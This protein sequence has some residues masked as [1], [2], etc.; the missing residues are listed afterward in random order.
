MRMDSS[1]DNPDLKVELRKRLVA[2]RERLHE[3]QR[4]RLDR[5]ICVHLLRFL[6]ERDCLNLAAF[7]AFRGEPDLM[8]ALEALHH[9]GRRVHLPVVTGDEMHFR[10]WT[11]ASHMQS[12][13][14]GIPEPV[15]GNEIPAERLELVMMPL[16]AFSA[17]GTRLGMGA[18]YYDR[19]FGFALDHPDAGPMLVGAAYSLQEVNSLPAQSWDVPLDAVITD[20]GLRVFRD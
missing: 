1:S 19:A 11:P 9:A 18:G 8:P 5:Q 20:R 7:H 17:T 16:V 4:R 14:F 15:D 10:R 3:H 12:N 2:E 13:R 6:D